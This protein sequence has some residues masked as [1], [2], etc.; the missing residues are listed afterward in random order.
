MQLGC[1]GWRLALGEGEVFNRLDERRGWCTGDGAR[2]S[3]I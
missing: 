3:G 2:V 1:M